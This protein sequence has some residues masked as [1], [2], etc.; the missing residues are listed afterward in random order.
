MLLICPKHATLIR[1]VKASDMIVVT[2]L[3]RLDRSRRE[4]L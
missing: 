2:K 3:D 4:M 1:G